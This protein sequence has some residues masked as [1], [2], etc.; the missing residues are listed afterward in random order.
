[1]RAIV[2]NRHG[3]ADVLHYRT[4]LPDPRPAS[5]EVIVEVS[6]TSLNRIDLF[7]RGG[8]PG[9]TFDFPHVPGADVAGTVV[10]AAPDVDAF[11]PGDRVMAWPLVACGD[12]PLCRKGRRALC[13]NWQYLGLH[14]HGSY[15][16]HVRIPADSL[17]RLPDDVSVET[18]A[19]LPVAGLT[20]YHALTSVGQLRSGETAL[21]WG[22]SGGLGT[23]AVQM[24]RHLGAQVIA[25]V[26]DAD[27][28]AELESLGPDLILNHHADDVE[29]AIRDFTDG[30]GVEL[31]LDSVG[32]QTFPI[33]FGLL[34]KGGRLLLCGKMTGMDVELSL[35][36]TYLRHL[37][38]HGLYLG[39]KSE[40]EALLQLVRDGTVQPVI[41]RRFPLADAAE[42]Q[43]A[44][45]AGERVGKL[46]LQPG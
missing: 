1:M 24:A 43:R 28:R 2:I 13:D 19:T 8:Y 21:I 27:K 42:A 35:H 22:G 25:T 7:V 38:I 36:R 33:G 40:L 44:L 6:A 29:S 39:E 14:R 18:A 20:A 45:E 41:D 11:A 37:S 16:E 31:V 10:E 23:F 3:S 34:Q 9:M 5:G 46:L 30:R 4:D 15:A 12:C 17:V 32:A 26:G